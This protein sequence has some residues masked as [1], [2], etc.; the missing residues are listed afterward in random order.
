[1]NYDG[2]NLDIFVNN[3]LVGTA[4]NVVPYMD[5]EM[6]VAGSENGIHGGICNVVYYD[7]PIPKQTIGTIYNL[8]KNS[9]PPIFKS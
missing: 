1:M 3:N 8:F 4:P 2:A 7:K 5:Y 9:D 6:I